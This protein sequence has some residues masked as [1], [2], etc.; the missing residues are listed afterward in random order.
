MIE[1][2]QQEEEAERRR[3]EEQTRREKEAQQP[4]EELEE[5]PEEEDDSDEPLI[6]ISIGTETQDHIQQTSLDSNLMDFDEE[7]AVGP[8]PQPSTSSPLPPHIF[9]P[10]VVVSKLQDSDIP[11][12]HSDVAPRSPFTPDPK[13]LRRTSERL[14]EKREKQVTFAETPKTTKT[15]KK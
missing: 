14:R 11:T 13:N 4:E 12:T 1:A 5:Q 7:G 9:D 10:L 6:N 3:Q 8:S 2:H 15:K